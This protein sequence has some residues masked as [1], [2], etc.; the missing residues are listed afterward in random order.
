MTGAL[1]KDGE[2]HP[3]Q[4]ATWRGDG[5]WGGLAEDKDCREPPATRGSRVLW[6]LDF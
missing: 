5:G 2:T 4:K 6:T 1:I 3:V